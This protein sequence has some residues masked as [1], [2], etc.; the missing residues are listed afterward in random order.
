MKLR[1]FITQYVDGTYEI[2]T[3]HMHYAFRDDLN[4]DNIQ[5]A[6]LPQLLFK[7]TETCNKEYIQAYFETN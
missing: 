3:K 1:F 7:I 4:Y 2:E 5:A 6:D